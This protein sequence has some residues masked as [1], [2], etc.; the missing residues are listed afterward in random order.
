MQKFIPDKKLH[1]NDSE[2]LM[3]RIDPDVYSTQESEG[4]SDSLN[5]YDF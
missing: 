2:V 5:A 3:L 1:F 4:T